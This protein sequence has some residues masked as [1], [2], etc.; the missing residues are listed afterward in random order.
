MKYDRIL[1][2]KIFPI[3]PY[4]NE[5]ISVEIQLDELD[6]IDECYLKAKATVEKWGES[7]L[8]PEMIAGSPILPSIP[9]EFPATTVEAIENERLKQYWAE[10]M[11]T[12]LKND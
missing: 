1:Y 4:Q 2:K 10:R 12:Q 7:G 11:K 6:N 9:M 8:M 5:S 3:G